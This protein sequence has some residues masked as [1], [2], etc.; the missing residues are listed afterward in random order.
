MYL[1]YQGVLF[2]NDNKVRCYA[3]MSINST[4]QNRRISVMG[5]RAVDHICTLDWS[6]EVKDSYLAAASSL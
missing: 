3:Q 4:R 6:D 5:A 1:A 2:C